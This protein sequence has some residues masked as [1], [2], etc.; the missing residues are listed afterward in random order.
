MADTPK[1]TKEAQNPYQATN[2]NGNTNEFTLD[3]SHLP[4]LNTDGLLSP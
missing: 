2:T 3:M 4:A 1:T